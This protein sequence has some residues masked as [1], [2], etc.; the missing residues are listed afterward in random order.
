MLG[1][2]QYFV[3]K[4]DKNVQSFARD[5]ESVWCH[6]KNR[7]LAWITTNF[8]CSCWWLQW[9]QPGSCCSSY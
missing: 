9:F 7:R 8:S 1:I 3:A 4:F 2:F 5:E 6:E